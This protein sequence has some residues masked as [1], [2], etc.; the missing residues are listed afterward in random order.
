MGFSEGVLHVFKFLLSSMHLYKKKKTF[1][2]PG[3]PT[4]NPQFVGAW[5]LGFLIF[6]I[7]FIL[8]GIPMLMFPRQ[9][10]GTD[11]VRKHRE[12]EMQNDRIAN[13]VKDNKKIG[14]RYISM[15]RALE[16]YGR[17]TLFVN[18]KVLLQING[19]VLSGTV[20][21]QFLVVYFSL[22]LITIREKGNYFLYFPCWEKKM[23]INSWK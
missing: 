13:E 16:S 7:V 20:T 8:A 15:P 22:A 18:R 4:T 23:C 21:F 3:V 10:P 17:L 11:E 12:K 19:M 2:S 14:T 9:L 1:Y 6:G 5:W